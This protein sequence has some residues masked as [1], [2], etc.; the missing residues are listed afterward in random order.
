MSVMQ[1][2]N[3]ICFEQ[4]DCQLMQF[5]LNL[6][7]VYL[8][9]LCLDICVLVWEIFFVDIFIVFG[10]EKNLLVFVYDI[11]G[12]Y[13]DFEVCIDLC[14]GLFDVCLCWIDECGDIEIFFGLIF[15]FGQVCL[16]DV[17]F[18]VLCFVY[19]CMLCWVKLGVNVLQ[20]YYVKKGIIILEMEYIVICE[21]MKL[22]EVW[23]VGLFDQQYL[24]YSFGVNILKEII[25]EFVC[26]EVV[27]GCVIILVN[28]N[29]IEFE[30]MIIG[31]NFLVKING[32]IGN[33]VL[34]LLIEEEVEKFIWGICWGVDMVMDLFIGKYI[35]EICEWILC[36]S[37]VLI[38]IVLIYQV[39][40]KVNGVVEDLIWE[41]F[42]DIL[43]EQ[44][45]QGVDYFIIYVGVLLCYVL[46]IVKWVI[47]IVFCGGLIMVKWCL[48]YYQENF[49]Y[50]YFEEIC[51]IM[52]VYDV[53]F[54]LG[55]GLCLGLVVDVNDVVQFGELEIFGELIK[56]VWKYDVQ[57]MIEGFGYVLM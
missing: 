3:I 5:F 24:G 20:M 49:F 37:L 53:S 6:C 7:K 57:V 55:D 9:G 23:V 28:I 15:E 51:E 35:Y 17:S 39:L 31:C 56:I 12:L 4:F 13:I 42:C 2:N 11:F 54:L 52:K 36:N 10:G 21:N 46:L 8:I 38:G 22:Q 48:V 32:N 40:E 19:V 14:K 29:Y 30:L 27:C 33:S 45:E 34:G 41:I 1:K 16:V 43:I 25:F 26:E 18:D 44:V 50:M 47:G